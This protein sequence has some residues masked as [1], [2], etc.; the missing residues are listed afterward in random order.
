MIAEKKI[1]I[2]LFIYAITLILAFKPEFTYA[3]NSEGN[4]DDFSTDVEDEILDNIDDEEINELLDEIFDEKLDFK[5][6]VK[7]VI[8]GEK[9]LDFN[10]L[11]EMAGS[12]FLSEIKNN[13]ESMVSVFILC[14]MAALFT[15][16]TKV[17]DTGNVADIGFYIIYLL[18]IAILLSSFRVTFKIASDVLI[19]MTSFMKV[20][21]PA[22]C[23]TIVAAKGA[24]TALIFY[25]FILTAIY[26]VEVILQKIALPLC[27]IYVIINLI[28][29]ISKEDL[30]SK[31]GELIRQ[32]VLW[33]IKWMFAIVMGINIVHSI[34]SPAMDEF[35]NSTLNKALSRLPGVGGAFGTVSDVVIGSGV[36][37]KNG[38]GTIILILL[39]LLTITPLVKLFVCMIMYKITA[40]IMQ[41]VGN[42]RMIF[43]VETISN[44]TYLL[45]KCVVATM[46]L[47]FLT[48]AI[49][50]VAA[51]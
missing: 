7:Q 6:M 12:V 41:P 40:A 32:V 30:F 23:V 16:F 2:V 9:S 33:I 27:K 15:N 42:K 5:L 19:Q 36:L 47:F 21:L 13:K 39:V 46:A 34:I 35:R 51:G 50:T 17:Y 10:T 31:M 25:E 24:S 8:S 38:V 1:K 28:N 14:V 44:G 48:M 26:V 11:C 4:Y 18:L 45:I 37:I 3:D 43:C 49:I 22:F 29:Q 20:L